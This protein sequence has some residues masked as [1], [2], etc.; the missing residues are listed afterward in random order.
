MAN[1]DKEEQS[2]TDEMFDCNKWISNC[3]TNL[4]KQN[5]G[6]E[7]E[8]ESWMM[9][10]KKQLEIEESLEE[11]REM[12]QQERIELAK[13]WKTWNH[14]DTSRFLTFVISRSFGDDSKSKEKVI[15]YF[16]AMK[17]SC[18]DGNDLAAINETTL[19]IIGINDADDRNKI[20]VYINQMI[21]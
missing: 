19:K 8:K 6:K 1:I 12:V 14:E 5:N 9:N 13:N 20:L 3:N 16:N 21:N 2:W 4:N 7:K 15:G 10:N 11:L 17:R 18:L